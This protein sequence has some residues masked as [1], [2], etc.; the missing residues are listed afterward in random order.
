MVGTLNDW[1]LLMITVDGTKYLVNLVK[2]EVF[3]DTKGIP[4]VSDKALAAEVL[5]AAEAAK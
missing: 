5:K 1:P 4:A 3:Y 2:K